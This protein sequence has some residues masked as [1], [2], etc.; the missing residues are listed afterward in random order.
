MHIF[1]DR[2]SVLSRINN[3]VLFAMFIWIFCW[4]LSH[5]FR[6]IQDRLGVIYQVLGVSCAVGCMTAYINC[7]YQFNMFHIYLFS[8]PTTGS[9]H[10][11]SIPCSVMQLFCSS[12]C[13]FQRVPSVLFRVCQV[14]ICPIPFWPGIANPH[15]RQEMRTLAEHEISHLALPVV[16]DIRFTIDFATVLVY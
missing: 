7:E 4:Q 3:M 13:W 5:N 11:V 9:L 2:R 15:I 10:R 14:R 12:N 1:R 16:R 6:S 8:I